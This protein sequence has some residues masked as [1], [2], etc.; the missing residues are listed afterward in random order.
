MAKKQTVASEL[1]SAGAAPARMEKPTAKR[2]TTTKHSASKTAVSRTI[3]AA[4]TP[5][6]E[7]VGVI[8]VDREEVAKLAYL[9]WEARGGHGGSAAD[10]WARAEQELTQV[11]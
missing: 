10:D 8:V 4:A 7:E 1:S 2:A 6:V 9:Y 3:A 11:K 5:S